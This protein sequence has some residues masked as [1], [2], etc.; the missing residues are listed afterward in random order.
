MARGAA[1]L[2]GGRVMV[3]Q[4]ANQLS[5]LGLLIAIRYALQR[6]QFDDGSGQCVRDR[7]VRAAT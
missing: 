3:A 2:V 7:A 6:R 1:P 4:S 5:K